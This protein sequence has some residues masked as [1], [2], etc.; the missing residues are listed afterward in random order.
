MPVETLFPLRS[1]DQEESPSVKHLLP[2]PTAGL[3]LT[4]RPAESAPVPFFPA[5]SSDRRRPGRTRPYPRNHGRSPPLPVAME[6]HR[7]P[8]RC[9][10]PEKSPFHRL[11]KS[12]PRPTS[13]ACGV[14]PSLP[15]GNTHT[16]L[17][18]SPSTSRETAQIAA[19][20]G[21]PKKRN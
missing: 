12:P 9:F 5:S 16:P 1:I 17:R 3:L 7:N 11:R 6:C 13:T 21:A 10:A 15:P 19:S 20:E 4:R 18:R 8:T 2:T 14:A